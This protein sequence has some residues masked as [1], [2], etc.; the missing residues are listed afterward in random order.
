MTST[1]S[2]DVPGTVTRQAGWR[3]WMTVEVAA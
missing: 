1:A 3:T 2:V